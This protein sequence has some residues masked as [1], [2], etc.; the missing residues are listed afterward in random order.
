MSGRMQFPDG[1]SRLGDIV[2]EH[3]V[4][5]R[6]A[7]LP[8]RRFCIRPFG[9]KARRCRWY[10]AGRLRSHGRWLVGCGAA[11]FVPGRVAIGVVGLGVRRA[12]GP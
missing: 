6:R 4:V 11:A 12:A 2:V 9:C 10:G 5:R 3:S 8:H 7:R 1:P